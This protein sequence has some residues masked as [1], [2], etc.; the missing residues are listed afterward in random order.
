AGLFSASVT[1]FIIESYKTL[2]PDEN[3]PT[4][5]LLS[6]IVVQLSSNATSE[7]T[8]APLLTSPQTFTPTPSAI[9]CN[10]FWFL[11]L[12]LSLICALSATLVE[13]WTRHYL[14]APFNQP[15]PQDRARISAYLFQGTKK[16]RMAIIVETIPL[17]LHISLFLFFAGLIAFLNGVNSLLTYII[18]SLLAFCVGLYWF[19]STLPILNLSSP[20]WTPLSSFT[21]HMLQKLHLLHRYDVNGNRIPITCDLQSAQELDATEI[22]PDRDERDLKAMCWTISA[23]RSDSAFEPFVEVIPGVISGIDYSAKWLMDALLK[24]DDISIKLD[25]RIPRLL[26]SC[27]TGY[28]EPSIAQRRVITCLKAIWSLT[29]LSLPKQGHPDNYTSQQTSCFKEDTLSLLLAIRKAFPT[30][31][32]HNHISSVLVVLTRSLLD[33]QIEELGELEARVVSHIVNSKRPDTF[34]S[35]RNE[36]ETYPGRVVH[37]FQAREAQILDRRTLT[38][39]EFHLAVKSILHHNRRLVSSLILD[40]A[41]LVDARVQVTLQSLDRCRNILNQ[42]GLNLALEYIDEMLRADTL[43]HESFNTIRRAFFRIHFDK[44]SG[45]SPPQQNFPETS[46][47]TILPVSINDRPRFS[48][49]SQERIVTY[50]EEATDHSTPPSLLPTRLP[51]TTISILVS[52]ARALSEPRLVLKAIKIV[53]DYTKRFP[54]EDDISTATLWTI[55]QSLPPGSSES[56]EKSLGGDHDII[57]AGVDLSIKHFGSEVGGLSSGVWSAAQLDL[58]TSHIYADAKPPKNSSPA[59]SRSSTLWTVN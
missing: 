56:A 14:Q 53:D 27:L 51:S 48:I 6:Q 39:P 32:I 41:D 26:T 2:R 5:Q 13:Q 7:L 33:S 15:A 57:S 18:A 31:I 20:Y 4:I 38:T 1:A 43:P 25:F 59:V 46:S 47:S 36:G 35:G 8:A 16:Y 23:L 29:M 12:S 11:S 10:V 24:Q 44:P 54:Q 58:L 19:V 40:P 45:T 50:L 21:W 9:V 34:T 52:L 55:L 17:L 3:A 30:N 37:Q 28:L 22:T 49:S 42:A